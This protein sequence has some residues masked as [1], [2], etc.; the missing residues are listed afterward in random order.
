M[1][2]KLMIAL[3]VLALVFGMVLIACD[4]GA[5]QTI[6]V[7]D[8]G[9]ETVYDMTLIPYLDKDGA[10]QGNQGDTRTKDVPKFTVPDWTKQ[11]PGED[12]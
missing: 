1:K 4:D 3:V 5:Y 10:I 6:T 8:D 9:T 2:L 7:K 12:D 11:Q